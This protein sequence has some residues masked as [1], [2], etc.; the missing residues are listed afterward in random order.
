MIVY[1]STTTI[2]LI[3]VGKDMADVRVHTV[4]KSEPFEK[5]LQIKNNLS[6]TRTWPNW[7]R[8]ATQMVASEAGEIKKGH[9]IALHQLIKGA[10]IEERWFIENVREGEN[11][12][13]IV[14]LFE[15]Q[16]RM[17]RNTA[18]SMKEY[19]ICITILMED[20]GVEIYSTW[21]S[22]GFGRIFSKRLFIFASTNAQQLLDD[23]CSI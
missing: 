10:L 19:R 8:G 20:G 7:H 18:R 6:D 17:E 12:Y 3:C 14:L 5:C 2:P 1:S 15:G 4:R 9:R 11:Y 23:L 21:K 22:K 16:S 13:E